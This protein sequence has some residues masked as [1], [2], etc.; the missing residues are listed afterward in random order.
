MTYLRTLLHRLSAAAWRFEIAHP[1]NVRME[2]E[3]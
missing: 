3:D 2:D 1:L